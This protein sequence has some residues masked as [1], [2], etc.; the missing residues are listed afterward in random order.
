MLSPLKNAGTPSRTIVTA[1]CVS[2][3]TVDPVVSRSCGYLDV[4]LCHL[5]QTDTTNIVI[6]I[7]SSFCARAATLHNHRYQTILEAIVSL[8][9]YPLLI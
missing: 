5:P 4:M 3:I 7:R 6:S 8:A 2:S 9:V 1:T